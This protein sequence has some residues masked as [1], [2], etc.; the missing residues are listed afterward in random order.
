MSTL[1]NSISTG[2]ERPKMLTMTLRVCLSSLTSSTAPLKLANG[3]FVDADLLALLELDL[4]RRLVLGHVGAEE[5]GADLL[6]RQRDRLVARSKEAGNARRVLDDV[7]EIV[8]EFHLDQNVA[9]QEDALDGV[10]LAVAQFC[11][12]LG[13]DHDAADAILQAE[14][15]NAALERLAHLPLEAG[16]GV[17]DVPLEILVDRRSE[18]LGS[19][20]MVASDR[21]TRGFY[22]QCNVVFGMFSVAAMSMPSSCFIDFFPGELG[23]SG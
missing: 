12:W 15:H 9:G 16:V 14:G 21:I 7:P 8:V 13:R 10:L 17:D 2:V 19:L 1:E 11:D 5:D 20:G 18:L 3:P 23:A 4:H 6:L 22:S